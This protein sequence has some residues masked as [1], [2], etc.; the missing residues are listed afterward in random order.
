MSGGSGWGSGSAGRVPAGHG[1]GRTG[2]PGGGA[3]G[4]G[5]AL[6][7]ARSW[8]AGALVYVIAGYVISRGLVDLLASDERLDVFAWR[9]ALEHVPVVLSTVLAVLAAARVLPY[10][11]RASRALHLSA[12][13]GAPVGALVYLYATQSYAS[14]SEG[15]LMP[16]VALATGAAIGLAVD[17]LMDDTDTVSPHAAPYSWRD[18]GAGAADYLG[19]ISVATG[20]LAAL[21]VAGVA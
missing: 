16:V 5:S 6:A 9:L 11:Q 13:L 4:V 1:P 7:L 19:G 17:G 14:G 2:R 12:A 15:V 21:A 18:G 20:V 3:S 10:E 8:I